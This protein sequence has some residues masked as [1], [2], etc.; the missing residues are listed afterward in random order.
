MGHLVS[1]EIIESGGGEVKRGICDLRS[2]RCFGI[3]VVRSLWLTASH[4]TWHKAQLP[5]KSGIPKHPQVRPL[6]RM[7]ANSEDLDQTVTSCQ[8][9]TAGCKDMSLPHGDHWRS[10]KAGFWVKD[11][12]FQHFFSCTRLFEK[13]LSVG[14]WKEQP[15]ELN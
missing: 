5:C 12:I 4:R 6:G 9:W 10:L 7:G 14:A 13:E 15:S 8:S 3:L 2:L 11:R 1:L